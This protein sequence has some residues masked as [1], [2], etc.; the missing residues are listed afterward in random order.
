MNK[1]GRMRWPKVRSPYMKAFLLSLL[2]GCLIVGPYIL[3]GKGIFIT[4]AD[5]VHQQIPFNM[6]CN[7]AIKNGDVFWNWN[8]D[9]GSAFIGYS[10]YNLGSPFFWISLLFSSAVFPYLIG[11]I[12]ILKYGVA[13]LTSFAFLQR[14]V[15]NKNYA[16]IAALLYAFSG[17]QSSNL[18][19]NHFHDVVA[20]FPLLLFTLDEMM[21]KRRFGWFT[22]AVALNALV[23]F[24][25]FPGEVFFVVLYFVCR[26]L[27][28][29]FRHAV[30]RIPRCLL[31]ACIGLGLACFIVL[32][33]ALMVSTNP[34][35]ATIWRDIPMLFDVRQYLRLVKAFLLPGDSEGFPTAFDGVYDSQALFLPMFSVS[36]VIAWIVKKRN[37]VT[38]FLV[39]LITATA[40]PL[41]NSVFYMAKDWAMFRWVYM[42]TLVMALATAMALDNLDDVPFRW[43]LGLAFGGTLLYAVALWLIPKIRKSGAFIEAP[44]AFA[45]QVI[46]ALGGIAA[47]WVFLGFCRHKKHFIPTL[48]VSVILF[49][50][51]AITLNIYRMKQN[52]PS[53]EWVKDT[54]IAST[55]RLD[56]PDDPSARFSFPYVNQGMVAGVPSMPCFNSSV[57][58]SI[59]E[60]YSNMGL[61][62]GNGEVPILEHDYLK[63]L[64]SMK[65]VVTTAPVDSLTE[66]SRS[67]D[68]NTVY[69][70]YE[71]ATA[72]PIGFT[73]DYYITQNRFLGLPVE[74]R[75]FVMSKALVVHEEDVDKLHGMRPLTEQQIEGLTKEEAAAE[76]E[77]RREE[78]SSNFSR[79]NR[80]F[81]S[82]IHCEENTLAFFS[83]TYDKGWSATV[84]GN[85][86]PVIL[87]SGMMAVPVEKG[88]NHIVF[89]YTVP[90]AAV[91]IGLTGVALLCYGAYLFISYRKPKEKER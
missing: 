32:P 58:G 44:R 33:S 72:L 38:G 62:R 77:N 42:L 46:L 74:E 54:Y 71:D 75:A 1:S 27:I 66:V 22:L 39:V 52:G 28:A 82:D 4:R 15:N 34:R 51:A 70:V 43:G 60:L 30:R 69:Y 81:T 10:F 80:S 2:T 56:L 17:Y 11:P 65:Y 86:V 84:N 13:G 9:L 50:S 57:S 26:Y 8:T 67:T 31:E 61:Y 20:L 25:F 19:Y 47:A 37:F 35:A 29:D 83:V 21:E 41:L 55:L 24:V 45:V 16:I 89:R 63:Q 49:A 36:L 76:L 48:T 87:S 73:Y 14:Y 59:F 7:D 6:M 88:D 12:L 90:G 85:E 23:N 5:F 79:D 40:I 68:E 78:S 3:L 91:G 53:S 64:L 18:L